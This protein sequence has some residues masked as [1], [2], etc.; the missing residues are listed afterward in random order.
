M[1]FLSVTLPSVVI[2]ISPWMYRRIVDFVLE[3]LLCRRSLWG[4]CSGASHLSSSPFAGLWMLPHSSRVENPGETSTMQLLV[5]CT[6]NLFQIQWCAVV[7]YP[8]TISKR[9]LLPTCSCLL[10]IFLIFFVLCNYVW[11]GGM[12]TCTSKSTSTSFQYREWSLLA[13]IF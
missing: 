9:Y 7:W 1:F 4:A 12:G 3:S 10:I 2:C 6:L 11:S 5:S 8:L 13:E